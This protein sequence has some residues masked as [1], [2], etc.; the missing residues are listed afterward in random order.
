MTRPPRNMSPEEARAL[1]AGP[2]GDEMARFPC[3]FAAPLYFGEPPSR[4]SPVVINNGTAS[5]LKLRGEYLVITCSHV[6]EQFRRRLAQ[7]QHCLFAVANCYFDPLPQII[8]EDK[9]V[10]SAVLQLTRQQA[11]DITRNSNG[12]GEAFFEVD[13]QTPTPVRVNDF[14]AYSGFPSDFRQIM[15][16]DELSFGTYSSGACRVTDVYSDYIT[17]QF[18]RDYWITNFIDA[19]PKT[20]G[21]LSGGPAFAIHHSPGGIFSYSFAGVIYRM[22]EGTESLFIRQAYALP[23][24]WENQDDAC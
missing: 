24:S 18:E 13:Q 7:G 6:I 12:I 1:M 3:R 4:E 16:L 9:V 11:D 10:D 20:L 21:G 2:L 15:S 5:L 14:L 19:E 8:A 23:V 22:H 17:C